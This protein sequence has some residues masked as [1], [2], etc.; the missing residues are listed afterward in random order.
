MA[1]LKP[2]DGTDY[3]LWKYLPSIPAAVVF[4]L[5]FTGV[6][7]AHCW[8]MKTTRTWFCIPF[9]IGGLRKALLLRGIPNERQ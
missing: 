8:R 6:T 3:F 2:V 4:L 9:A 5:L 7:A 1:Q